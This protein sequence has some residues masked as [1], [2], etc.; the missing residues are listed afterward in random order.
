MID[1]LMARNKV[2]G[3][4]ALLSEERTLILN[5]PLGDLKETVER[6]EKMLQSL[7]HLKAALTEVDLQAIRTKAGVNE[8]L[9]KASISGVK[10]AQILI[11]QQK[12]AASTMGTYTNTG[13]KLEQVG[14]ANLADRTV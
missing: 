2:R 4:L 8:K 6:R 13:E 9:L 7:I 12:H 1:E 5:G 14:R 10:A 3:I 11:S